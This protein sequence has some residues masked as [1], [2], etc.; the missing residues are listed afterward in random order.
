MII[1]NFQV[2]ETL[3]VET[4]KHI[5]SKGKHADLYFKMEAVI[6]NLQPS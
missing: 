5:V 1:E 6:N 3:I 4:D 2:Q